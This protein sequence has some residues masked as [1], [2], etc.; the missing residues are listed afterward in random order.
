LGRSRGV[1][2]E[3]TEHTKTFRRTLAGFGFTW[4]RRVHFSTFDGKLELH[5][6]RNGLQNHPY[7]P[8][9]IQETFMDFSSISHHQIF[10]KYSTKKQHLEN[11]KSGS[12]TKQVKVSLFVSAGTVPG[13][14]VEN[15]PRP[16]TW[17]PYNRRWGVAPPHQPLRSPGPFATRFTECDHHLPE[18]YGATP[19]TE[20]TSK[21]YGAT[22]TNELTI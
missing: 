19:T 22:P 14:L 12:R 9:S 15:G 11:R 3:R 8:G 21:H 17:G 13:I 18:T 10:Q 1:R 4:H 2:G 6:T 5:C 7:C 20:L 16:N